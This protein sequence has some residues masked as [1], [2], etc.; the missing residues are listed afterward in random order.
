MPLSLMRIVTLVTATSLSVLALIGVIT[1]RAS[2][3]RWPAVDVA[4]PL[5]M[6][7]M[8]ITW[9]GF[10]AAH[11]RDT[12]VNLVNTR[13]DA[14]ERMLGPFG[15]EREAAGH[16]AAARMLAQPSRQPQRPNGHPLVPGL[17]SVD[18]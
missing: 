15:D 14:I 6:T 7:G 4:V 18:N 5:V 3:H 16:V 10:L 2:H 17:R 13:A 1:V 9:I 12:I 11:C 8:G